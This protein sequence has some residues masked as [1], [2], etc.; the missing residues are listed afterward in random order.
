[1][2]GN[3]LPLLFTIHN[4]VAFEKSKSQLST[5]S[6]N[7]EKEID[8]N[9]SARE[10]NF[11]RLGICREYQDELIKNIECPFLKENKDKVFPKIR[12]TKII[13]GYRHVESKISEI[14]KVLHDLCV[15]HLGYDIDI[16][17]SSFQNYF[18]DQ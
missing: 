3:D 5:H 9:N 8:L 2:T 14:S 13:I 17:V 6:L 10:V 18:K 1:L 15:R 4:P 12:I 7:S 16:E 11:K